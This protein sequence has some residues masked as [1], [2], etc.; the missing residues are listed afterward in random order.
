MRPLPCATRTSTFHVC[1][2]RSASSI[3]FTWTKMRVFG[4]L[5]CC[6]SWRRT[7]S[8]HRPKSSPKESQIARTPF[9]SAIS[10]RARYEEDC[11]SSSFQPR[12]PAP[13]GSGPEGRFSVVRA[14][15]N[16]FLKNSGPG[17]TEKCTPRP[18]SHLA[19]IQPRIGKRYAFTWTWS[20]ETEAASETNFTGK[21]TPAR[22]CHRS[23]HNRSSYT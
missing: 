1:A 20:Q 23:E 6:S 19:D 21:G 9:S 15:A 4:V 16:S 2:A 17:W 11:A 14:M 10:R 3:E 5:P 18:K 22:P 12:K 13:M 7:N 8:I